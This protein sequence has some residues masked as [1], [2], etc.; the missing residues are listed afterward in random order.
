[1][2]MGVVISHAR[3]HDFADIWDTAEGDDPG[4]IQGVG[5]AVWLDWDM[6]GVGRRLL[7]HRQGAKA[8]KK[9]SQ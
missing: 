8:A 9:Q 6:P 1:M 7:C 5:I 3:G 4:N 2:A